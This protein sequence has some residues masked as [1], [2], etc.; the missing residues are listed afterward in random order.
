MYPALTAPM[1]GRTNWKVFA[2]VMGGGL[3]AVG[4]M[5]GLV[6]NGVVAM[7]ADLPIP[8]TVQASSIDGQQFTLAPSAQTDPAQGAKVVMNGTLTNMTITKQVTI[9]GLGTFNINISAGG[10]GTPVQANGMTVF[11]SS[12]GGDTSFP[13]GLTMDASTGS[14]SASQLNMSNATL[15]VPYLQTN[16]ITLPNMSLSITPASSS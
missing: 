7:A 4:T 16:S 13:S 1:E 5:T 2:A 15:Q 12:L 11:A 9:P 6:M 3:A 14:L 8:F 10:K